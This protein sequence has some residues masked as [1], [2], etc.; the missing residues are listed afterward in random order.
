MNYR[1][2]IYGTYHSNQAKFLCGE[3]DREAIK[4]Q[5]PAWSRYYGCFL[6]EDRSVRII[7]LGCGCGGF[8]WWLQ[9][10]GYQNVKGVDISAEQVELSKRLGIDNIVESDIKDF[11]LKNREKFDLIFM[12][13]ILEHFSKD[14]TIDILKAVFGA[15]DT[16]GLVLIQTSNAA[17]PFSGRIRYGDFTHEIS[18]TDTSLAQVLRVAGFEKIKCYPIRPVSHGLVSSIRFLLW[19]IIEGLLRFCLLVETGSCKGI[20]TQ[21]LLCSA[22]R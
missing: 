2:S 4:K 15:L 17:S 8:V 7:E 21:G 6:P 9:R 3:P 18:F 10:L 11:F 22:K 5:F 19:K 13:D 20:M 12:K 14:E 16:N 1:E